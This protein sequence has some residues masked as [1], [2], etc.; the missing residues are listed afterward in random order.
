MIRLGCTGGKGQIE[1]KGQFA[2]FVLSLQCKTNKAGLNSGLFYRC[3]PGELMNGYESQIQNQFKSL[4]LEPKLWFEFRRF[5]FLRQRN[6]TQFFA[7]LRQA[8]TA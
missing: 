5:G 8:E 2:D 7:K 3:I 4:L 1:S 6:L